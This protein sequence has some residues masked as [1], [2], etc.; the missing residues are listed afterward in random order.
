MPYFLNTSF[1]KICA[2]YRDR[3]CIIVFSAL[4][5][6]QGRV[7]Y[8]CIQCFVPGT[9]TGIVLSSV[10]CAWYRD[11][12]CI[13]VFGALCLVQGQ[14]LYYYLQCFVPG[15]G[16]GIIVFSALCLVQG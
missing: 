2:W 16:T 4:C 7:L 12:Y 5:L 13:I 14:V 1:R 11:R 3:Y 10:L 8:Y 15:T 6:V 9:G